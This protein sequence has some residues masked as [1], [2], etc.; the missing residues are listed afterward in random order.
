M[1]AVNFKTNLFIFINVFFILIFFKNALDGIRTIQYFVHRSRANVWS[2]FVYEDKK[3]E[4]LK[5]DHMHLGLERWITNST[6]GTTAQWLNADEDLSAAQHPLC[7]AL[8]P[9]EDRNGEIS[10]RPSDTRRLIARFGTSMRFQDD[11]FIYALPDCPFGISD[12]TSNEEN[13]SQWRK[14]NKFVNLRDTG[15]AVM[16]DILGNATTTTSPDVFYRMKKYFIV[17][18]HAGLPADALPTAWAT[19]MG[20]RDMV[21]KFHLPSE[22][23]I[24]SNLAMGVQ[25]LLR[26]CLV[27]AI[28][29]SSIFIVWACVA[30]S[31]TPPSIFAWVYIV[32]GIID[33]VV[34]F[35]VIVTGMI[36]TGRDS[37]AKS[38]PTYGDYG[39]V[40]EFFH[41]FLAVN[42]PLF[43]LNY[44]T[45]R[46]YFF[47]AAIL[48]T[49]NYLFVDEKHDS[50]PLMPD[51]GQAITNKP[52][53]V[54]NRGHATARYV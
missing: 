32:H 21:S 13:P 47:I 33:C 37:G 18:T 20:Y 7:R 39:N 53:G 17:T 15:K 14:L 12:R 24:H 2:E 38:G 52:L 44:V 29:S 51:D 6:G 28:I 3:F 8:F 23:K 49:N 45:T 22:I 10:V 30:A 34:Y 16:S 42:I 48:R 1:T 35:L 26:T 27:L 41:P 19:G 4:D 54:R 40:F 36:I 46:F 5:K 9:L 43:T 50:F 31:I 25:Q 11:H